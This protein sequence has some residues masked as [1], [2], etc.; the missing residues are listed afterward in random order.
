MTIF[1]PGRLLRRVAGGIGGIVKKAPL[2]RMP[3]DLAL[4][5]GMIA[6]CN[7][8]LMTG[9]SGGALI[10]SWDR[11]TAGEWHRLATHPFVHVSWYHFLLDAGAF[12]LLYTGLNERRPIKR[13]L[14]V[15]ICGFCGLLAPLLFSPDIYSQGLCGL[16][17]MAH[18]LMAFSGLEMMRDKST[19]KIG[20]CCLAIVVAKSIYEAATGTVFFSFLLFGLCGIPI[21]VCHAGGVL[22]GLVSFLLT[23]P[24]K[25]K[26]SGA[27]LLSA[28]S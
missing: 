8:H 11:V 4:L 17:G 28:V 1:H 12:L 6:L 2:F 24:P 26:Q 22:G 20:F 5:L 19:A 27:P 13:L 16:S 9:E 3:F 14:T 7:L 21:A 10:F 23:A 18:G 15:G 25:T